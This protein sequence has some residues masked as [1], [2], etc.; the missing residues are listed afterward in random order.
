MCWDSS[1]TAPL[2]NP[3]TA[4]AVVV[5]AAALEPIQ[6]EHR[7]AAAV[8]E[9][10]AA[11][12]EEPPDVAGA[13]DHAERSAS[14]QRIAA[15][16]DCHEIVGEAAAVA[17]CAALA[18]ETYAVLAAV[19]ACVSLVVAYAVLVAAA[20]AQRI[21]LA[22]ASVAAPVGVGCTAEVRAARRA[23]AGSAQPDSVAQGKIADFGVC[24]VVGLAWE[25]ADD[26]RSRVAVAAVGLVAFEGQTAAP[27][28][29]AAVAIGRRLDQSKRELQL[30][31]AAH[32]AP[33]L[34][35]YSRARDNRRTYVAEEKT[36]TKGRVI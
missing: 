1:A 25:A 33:D 6:E 22:V 29:A 14:E 9:V 18:V 20:A 4:T 34:Q 23:Q 7:A 16:A 28:I 19:V 3:G 17:A 36:A 30:A 32:A 31:A 27:S 26:Q 13:A 2:A 12:F 5:V 11:A 15:A 24:V 35:K 21:D 10:G 8:A